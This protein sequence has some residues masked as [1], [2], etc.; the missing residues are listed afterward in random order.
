MDGIT[1][2]TATP[3]TLK[4]APNF[5]VNEAFDR[6]V[7]LQNQYSKM[8]KDANK[9]GLWQG[10]KEMVPIYGK[11][12]QGERQ[13][14]VEMLK[15]VNQLIAQIRESMARAYENMAKS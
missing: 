8:E 11:K 2:T 14:K 10:L 1:P 15:S 6:S 13:D 7:A 9:V 4:P 3:N 5:N 12:V